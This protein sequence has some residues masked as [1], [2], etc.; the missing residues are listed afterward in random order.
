MILASLAVTIAVAASGLA[1]LA[2]A[3]RAWSRARSI[4][5]TQPRLGEPESLSLAE[6]LAELTRLVE[7]LEQSALR[8][9]AAMGE[10]IAGLERALAS[11]CAA[12]TRGDTAAS[13]EPTPEPRRRTRE[14]IADAPLPANVEAPLA[15]VALAASPSATPRSSFTPVYDLA[16][17]RIP[18]GEIARRTSLPIGE[19]EVI[20]GLRVLGIDAAA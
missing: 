13:T 7:E 1:L 2:L 11:L 20:L 12:P 6:D 16:D 3:P 17:Q 14:V 8:Q 15:T 18:P 19:V 5:R 4:L 10:R 9:N